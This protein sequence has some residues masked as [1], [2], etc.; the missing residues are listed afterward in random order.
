MK[1]EIDA[2]TSWWMSQLS[3]SRTDQLLAFRQALW[4]SLHERYKDHWYE[5]EPCRGQ[6]YRCISYLPEE[7]KVDSLL[8]DSA[9]L[10]GLDFAHCVQALEGGVTMWVDPG[11][12]EVKFMSS[13]RHKV[14]YKNSSITPAARPRTRSFQKYSPGAAALKP[15][16]QQQQAQQQQ[17]QRP[18]VVR[19]TSPP[20]RK[21]SFTA[22]ERSSRASSPPFIPT[23]Q[24]VA[25]NNSFRASSPPFIP[26][27]HPEGDLGLGYAQMPPP[28]YSLGY[29]GQFTPG[30]SSWQPGAPQCGAKE[31]DY[32]YGQEQHMAV[33]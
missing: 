27:S 12:V 31:S 14:V 16:Y 19:N 32:F 17:Q 28:T 30:F 15:S 4:S 10:A 8:I 13:R 3:V 2:A 33:A 11:D 18:P 1:N 20:V 29:G 6:G 21:L 25:N 26:T 9:K 7:E 23:G 5:E 22:E 24:A